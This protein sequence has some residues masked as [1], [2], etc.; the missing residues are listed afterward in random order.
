M[1]PAVNRA[2]IVFWCALIFALFGP[3]AGFQFW[4]LVQP[5]PQV[6]V[7]S[8]S[9]KWALAYGWLPALAAGVIFGIG[10]A[11]LPWRRKVQMLRPPSWAM[12]LRL[13]AAGLMAGVTGCAL[14]AFAAF[15][16]ARYGNIFYALRQ[17]ADGFALLAWFGA[18]AGAVCG[19]LTGPVLRA[20]FPGGRA[21][22]RNAAPGALGEEGQ[23]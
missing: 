10:A 3:V 7:F 1:N 4:A 17:V 18:P 11:L 12:L 19:M 2:L 15:P 16:L 20:L 22:E 9:L 13:A 8:P 23:S 14:A 6:I 21:A 5:P